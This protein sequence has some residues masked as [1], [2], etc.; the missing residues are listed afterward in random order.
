MTHEEIRD[1][2]ASYALGALEA[3]ERDNVAAHLVGCEKCRTEF[4]EYADVADA[5]PEALALAAPSA[6]SP[7]A[8]SW[9]LTAVR[10]SRRRLPILRLTA[11]AVMVALIASVILG[12][13][14]NHALAQERARMQQ[15]TSREEIV[16]EVVDASSG[17][18]LALRPP[19]PGSTSYGKVFTRPELPYVVAMAGRLPEAPADK[20]YHLW[21]T[22]GDGQTV[23]AGIIEPN[24]AGFGS[25]VYDA[26]SDDP[27]PEHAR[28]TLDQ[29]GATQPGGVPVLL[30]DG[31]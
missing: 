25:L 27:R 14:L 16:F 24:A 11:A 5:L 17:T 12:V 4:A 28:I 22:F 18:K 23:R 10:P 29:P 1:L 19:V 31:G 3:G 30:W 9:L 8:R 20:V 21:L 6:V 13:R 15:L 7:S 26:R 2:L